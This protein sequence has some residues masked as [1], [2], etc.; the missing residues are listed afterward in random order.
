MQARLGFFLVFALALVLSGCASIPLSTAW[1]MSK[2]TPATLAQLDPA[3][4]RVKVSVPEGFEVDLAAT[5]LTVELSDDTG[6]DLSERLSLTSLQTLRETRPAGIFSA[7]VPVT[8]HV[9]ALSPDGVRQ[10]RE[11]QQRF[12]SG[13]SGS[14]TFGVQARFAQVP[15]DVREITFWADLKLAL[16]EPFFPLIDG[17]TIKVDWDE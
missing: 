1:R 6:P 15:Q 8:S 13:A 11:V 10:L 7:D 14:Y 12:L 17:A 9:L 3:Q 4:V 2:F 5:E 16:D